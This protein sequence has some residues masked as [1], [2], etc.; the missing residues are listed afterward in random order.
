MGIIFYRLFLVCCLYL[1][2]RNPGSMIKNTVFAIAFCLTA[3]IAHAQ[4]DYNKQYFNGKQLFRDGKYNLAMETFK[5]LLSYDAKNPFAE[6]ASFYY[7]ISAYHQGYRAV[8]KDQLNQI[9]S[10]YSKWDKMDE[11]NFWL[12][13]IHMD[14]K[15]YFQG[16]KILSTIHDKKFQRDIDALKINSL[17]TV[18]DIETLK[19]MREEHPKDELIA[20]QLAKTLS[21]NLSD[22]VNKALLESLITSHNLKRSEYIPEAPKSFTKDKY[23]VSVVMPFMANTLEP[24][25]SKKRNQIVLDFYEGMKLAADTLSKKNIQISLRAYDTERDNSKIRNILGTEELKNTDLII[26][27]FFQE[28]SKPVLDFA[29]ANRINVMNPF[30]NNNELLANNPHS[31]LFQPTFE[32]IGLKSGEFLATHSA[33]KN[34]LVFY[35]PTKRDSILTANFV[36]SAKEK[37]LEIVAVKKIPKDGVKDILSILATPTEYDEFKYPKEFTLKKD[38]L[39]SIFVASDDPLLYVKVVSGV[40][41][42]GDRILVLGQENWLD[43]STLDFEKYQTLPI[44]LA[45]P[46]FI[47]ANDPDVVAFIKKFIKVHGRVPSLHAK[48]GYELMLFTGNQLKENGVYFQEALNRKG[49]FPGVLYQ[50]YNFQFSRSNQFVPFIR[51]E[52]DRMKMIQN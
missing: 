42:R 30:V 41:T 44:V 29:L 46:N 32:T 1:K 10:A 26:G 40:E 16:L 43:N 14:N 5:P 8:A 11:V 19:M 37:G 7:A 51:Y 23:S 38:S 12:A 15:D 3:V 9:R 22:P 39:G 28:E 27:P 18:T 17:K 35:G 21:N 20:R 49:F 52:D 34:C 4:V 50:G 36:Q 6:Y 45:A 47:T 2:Q 13:K 48:M 33:K 31:F 25:P 24:T